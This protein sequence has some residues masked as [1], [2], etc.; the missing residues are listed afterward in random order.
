MGSLVNLK[1]YPGYKGVSVTE[2]YTPAERELFKT[3]ATKAKKRN[4]QEDTNSNY[5]WRV[6]GSPKNG[7]RLKKCPKTIA[8]QTQ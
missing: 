1:Q 6:R 2:E 4:E 5:I 3:W 8:S 7:L